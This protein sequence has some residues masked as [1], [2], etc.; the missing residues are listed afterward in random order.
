MVSPK[1]SPSFFHRLIHHPV[2]FH[3]RRS[4]IELMVAF[5]VLAGLNVKLP[6]DK[7]AAKAPTGF[8]LVPVPPTT[9]IP[10]PLPTTIPRVTTTTQPTTVPS[11]NVAT[12]VPVS[13]TTSLLLPLGT[14]T[15]PGS[16]TSAPP[17]T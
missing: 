6:K 15:V 8:V 3:L 11:T 7:P 5:V 1:R 4:T 14:T 10:K 13:T 2:Q 17:H 9:T 12:T 16:S